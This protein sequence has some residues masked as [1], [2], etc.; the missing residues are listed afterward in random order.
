MFVVAYSSQI[1]S[2]HTFTVCDS[3]IY[4]LYAQRG[5]RECLECHEILLSTSWRCYNLLGFELLPYAFVWLS[6]NTIIES[7]ISNDIE[8]RNHNYND[9]KYFQRINSSVK[10]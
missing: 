4:K 5:L 8:K 10:N 6:V 2:I 1:I 9:I 7:T 3:N